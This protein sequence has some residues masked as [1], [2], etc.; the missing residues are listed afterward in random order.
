V[1]SPGVSAGLAIPRVGGREPVA[2]GRASD[3]RFAPLGAPPTTGDR[4]PSDSRRG[5]AVVMPRV[6]TPRAA[7]PRAPET[8]HAGAPERTHMGAPA[9]PRV[10]MPEQSSQPTNGYHPPPVASKPPMTDFRRNDESRAAPSHSVPS[11]S[12]QPE[13][14]APAEHSAPVERA[15]PAERTAPRSAPGS[16]LRLKMKAK[17]GDLFTARLEAAARSGLRLW[18]NT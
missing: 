18:N 16:R 4:R 12:A 10:V 14:A 17:V 8:P 1:I 9:T 11:N 3:P 7:T 15:A 5:P 13:R 6:D 2:A